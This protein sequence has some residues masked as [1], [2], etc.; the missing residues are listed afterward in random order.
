MSQRLTDDVG[1]SNVGL[2]I[3]ATNVSEIDEAFERVAGA[4]TGG[5]AG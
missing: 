1:D 2:N 3:E 4:M 5:A